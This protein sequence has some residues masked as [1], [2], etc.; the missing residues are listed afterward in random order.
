MKLIY[1]A[2]K[3]SLRQQNKYEKKKNKLRFKLKNIKNKK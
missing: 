3:K 1:T 2:G